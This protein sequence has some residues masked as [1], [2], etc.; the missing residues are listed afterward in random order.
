M[1]SLN[2]FCRQQLLSPWFFL[3]Q[4]LF[5]SH[6]LPSFLF[7]YIVLF[8]LFLAIFLQYNPRFLKTEDTTILPPFLTTVNR[9]DIVIVVFVQFYSPFIIIIFPFFFFLLPHES[10]YSRP[11]N[12]YT[13][14]RHY[15]FVLFAHTK[16][17]TS[18]YRLVRITITFSH[19]ATRS[20]TTEAAVVMVLAVYIV[21]PSLFLEQKKEEIFLYKQKTFP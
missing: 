1:C 6:P 19:G 3:F 5:Y 11:P 18:I 14:T 4:S 16:H 7:Y 10:F 20:L 2:V 12:N 13:R 8:C 21:Q 15:R 17:G 9:Y